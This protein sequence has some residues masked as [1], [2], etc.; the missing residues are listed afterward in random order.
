[1]SNRSAPL[2]R[3]T[4]VTTPAI[5]WSMSSS[6]CEGKIKELNDEVLTFYYY[7]YLEDGLARMTYEAVTKPVY[8]EKKMEVQTLW[9]KLEW[10]PY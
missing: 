9:K 5:I 2:R 3:I 4:G 7:Y 6:L 1:M 10:N 8:C